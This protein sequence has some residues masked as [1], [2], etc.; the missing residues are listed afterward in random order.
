MQ[1]V[2]DWLAAATTDYPRR[3]VSFHPLS[4][5]PAPWRRI[6]DWV[7]TLAVAIGFV[8]AFE[9]EV[10]KPFRIPSAS[11]EHTLHC[12]RPALR[13]PRFDER[14]RA[15]QPARLRLR[16]PAARSRSS[17]SRLPAE[18][19][20]SAQPSDAGTTV[21][22][23]AD[24]TAG[25]DGARGRPRLHLDPPSRGATT[26]TKLA[27]P[28]LSPAV[29]LA[30]SAYFGQTWKVPRGRVLHGRRQPARL[31]RLAILG[32]RSP[33]SNLIGPVISHRTGRPGRISYHAGGW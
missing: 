2:G 7:V 3:G 25:R 9:A 24:R 5:L 11:M 1:V 19:E 17:S 29:R 15:R 16:Q 22:Q 13:L 4:R 33:R 21:R 12:A 8:L 30:D 27:E 28:Y 26:W 23:A 32:R 6:V 31:V 20:P 14:P 18:G 10:A